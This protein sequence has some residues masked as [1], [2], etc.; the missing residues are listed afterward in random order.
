[1]KSMLPY[2]L[3]DFEVESSDIRG[4]MSLE[5]AMAQLLFAAMRRMARRA[6]KRANAAFYAGAMRWAE[7]QM[8]EALWRIEMECLVPMLNDDGTDSIFEELTSFGQRWP[9]QYLQSERVFVY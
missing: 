7:M 6:G 5:Q 1:M 9:V 4:R 2:P 8:R 3:G